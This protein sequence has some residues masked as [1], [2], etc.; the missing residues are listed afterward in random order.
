MKQQS[1]WGGLVQVV[2]GKGLSSILRQLLL[3]ANVC[4]FKIVLWFSKECR[5]LIFYNK[6]SLNKQ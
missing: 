5:V 3:H 1:I 6:I 4:F 2:S